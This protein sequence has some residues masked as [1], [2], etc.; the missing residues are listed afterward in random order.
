V[1]E[2][3]DDYSL[4]ELE[5]KTGRTHQI[6]VHLS[7]LGYPIV[8][9]DYYQGRHLSYGDITGPKGTKDHSPRDILVT[10]QALHAA[11][12]GFTHPISDQPMTF[13]APLPDDM[14]Q[15]ITLLRTHQEVSRPKT[16]GAVIDLNTMLPDQL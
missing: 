12:L 2:I 6:R 11:L 8:G 1:R 13:Q 5:L 9:D 15:L 10:R 7:H 3:Y 14:K 16:A 4:L